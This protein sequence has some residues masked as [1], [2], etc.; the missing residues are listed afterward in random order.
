MARI[1]TYPIDTI[2]TAKDKWIGTDSAGIITK[3]FSAEDVAAY[4]NSSGVLESTS[5]RFKFK[6]TTQKTTGSFVLEIDAGATVLFSAVTDIIISKKDLADRI[7]SPMYTPLVGSV[8]LIQ[9]AT[10]PSTFGVFK[11]TSSSINPLDSDF[12]DVSLSHYGGYGSLEDEEDYLISLLTYD[13]DSVSDKHFVFTQATPSTSWS[14]NHGL[15]KFPSV[16]VVD[17]AGTQVQGQVDYT[18][19]NNLTISFENQFSGKAYIN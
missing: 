2:V 5:S 9:S 19:T 7:V 10:N 11:W 14:V 16:T 8:I 12:Y 3:N 13:I 1:S 4:L 15:D 18:D 17:S 6:R